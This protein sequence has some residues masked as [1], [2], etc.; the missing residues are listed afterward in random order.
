[1]NGYMPDTNILIRAVRRPDSPVARRLSAHVGIDLCISAITWTELVDA[2]RR[3]LSGIPILPF[4]TSAGTQAGRIMADLARRGTPIGDRDVLIAAHA[5][6]LGMT[7]V[8]HNVREFARVSGLRT[9]DWLA[10]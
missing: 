10:E 6:S 2:A 1:M 4:G 5:L 3:L 7:V 9:E 8:T